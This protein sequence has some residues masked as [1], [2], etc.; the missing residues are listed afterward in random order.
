M[1][2]YIYELIDPISNE[3]RY[4]GRTINPKIRL[5]GHLSKSKKFNTHRDCWIRSLTSVGEKPILNIIDELECSWEYSYK[6]ERLYIKKYLKLGHRLTNTDD[7]G[8]G[9]INK[10]ITKE[11]RLKISKTV[12]KLHMEG[13]LSCGRKPVDLYDLKA[14]FIKSFVSY[15]ECAKYIGVSDKHIQSHFKRG[16]KRLRDYIIV[17]KGEVA[18]PWSYTKRD[19]K[20]AVRVKH[21]DVI[22]NSIKDA[23]KAT[24]YACG[25][26]WTHLTNKVKE[27]KFKY[28]DK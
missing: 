25:T 16:G 15:T 12:K 4:I 19:N 22:Y 13:K 21:G 23:S 1:K 20:A 7:K 9:G 8:V 11:Q 5:R 6:I 3:I 24:G 14:N 28:V 17:H 10:I 2:V 18:I 27:P 26:I